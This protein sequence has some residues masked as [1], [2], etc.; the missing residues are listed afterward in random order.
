VGF[1]IFLIIMAVVGFS[2]FQAIRRAS[3]AVRVTNSAAAGRTPSERNLQQ[4]QK[5]EMLIESRGGESSPLADMVKAA[6]E[7]R[8]S[9][10]SATVQ[11]GRTEPEPELAQSL[12]Q[13]LGIA[14][15]AAA[16]NRLDVAPNAKPKRAKKSKAAHDTPAADV[17]G[18]HHHHHARQP[19][20]PLRALPPLGALHARAAILPM[21]PLSPQTALAVRS[22]SWR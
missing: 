21:Q 5:L 18:L 3:G 7:A 19:L 1:L 12:R 20:D 11:I 17:A 10:E 8:Q 14:A 4:L 22:D 6:L 13:A 2:I 15:A 9:G 16:E